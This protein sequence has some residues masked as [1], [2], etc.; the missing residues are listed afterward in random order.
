M[1]S[2]APRARRTTT[3]VGATAVAALALTLLPAPA[4]A[5]PAATWPLVVTE[6]A[7]DNTGYDDFE[8]VELT[9]T[10]DADLVL[11][12][13]GYQLAY[14][15]AD[16]GDRSRDK[17]LSVPA[18]TVVP[19][20]GTVVLW[21]Q[22]TAGNVDTTR[23]DA[24]DFRAFWAQRG[25]PSTD[26]P[27]VPLSGQAGIANGGDRGIRVLSPSGEVV[28]W[29]FVPA[30]GVGVDQVVQ[31]RTPVDA[32]TRAMDVLATL[33][34]PSPGVVAPEQLA[35]RTSADP[36][37]TPSPTDE[38][39]PTASPTPTTEPTA[40][41]TPTPT[42]T[43]TAAP[44]TAPAPPAD[45][46]RGLLQVTELM[47][48]ST[49]VG[50]SDGYEYVEVYNPTTRP[51]PFADHVI[52]YLYPNEDYTNASTTLWPATPADA[53]VPPGGTLVLWVKNGGNQ[54]LTRADFRTFWGVDL[55]D[56][57]IL[58]MPAGGMANGSPRGV[59]VMTQTG[60]TVSRA[61]YN[62]AG[63]R[64]VATDRGI[65]YAADAADFSRQR[66]I[67]TRAPSPGTVEAD[68]APATLTTPVADA[69]APTVAD[70]SPDVV[71]PAAALTFA[72]EVDDDRQVRRVELHVRSDLDAA[73]RVLSLQDDGSGRFATT[74]P[75]VDLIGKSS[76]TY[77]WVAS[78]GVHLVETAPV[79]LPVLGASDDPVRL[80]VADGDL[81]ARTA[82]VSVAAE[83][84]DPADL[85]LAV[86]GTPLTPTAPQLEKPAVF[87]V[88]VTATD[89]AFRNGIVL[90]SPTGDACHDG[91]VLTIFE[92]G[93]YSNVETV[94][95]S[96]PLEA[97]RPGEPVTVLVSAGTKAYP[98]DDPDEN[99]D[100]FTAI[101]PRLVLPDGRTLV[102]AGYTGG[103]IAMG[104]SA[105]KIGDYAATFTI[106]DDA[107]TAVGHA[108]DTTTVTD[109]THTVTG[110]DGTATASADVVVDNTAPVVAIAVDADETS[111][112]GLQGTIR[113]DATAT[114]A[115]SS[116]ASLTATLD[117]EPVTLPLTTSSLLLVPGEH[118]VAVTATDAAGNA[119]TERRTFTTPDE[120][121][122]VAL[123][124]PEDGAHVTGPA[125]ELAARV[126]DPTG[127]AL[128]VSFHK[129]F[130]FAATD[131]AVTA[132]AGTTRDA[133]ATSRD[134]AA[135]TAEQRAALTTT[136]GA[137]V[138][139][140][141]GDALPYQLFD[142]AVPAEAGDGARVV[143]TWDG[144]AESG[145]TV[146]LHV[147]D[148]AAGAW[149]EVDRHVGTG[150]GSTEETFTL[151]ADVP[152]AGHVAD[153]EARFLVQHSEGWAGA[154][155]STRA[156]P[157]TPAHPQDTP[158]PDYDFTLAWESD[159]QYYNESFYDH[160]LAIHE[161]LLDRRD[162]LNLQYLFH[163]GDIVDN[164]DQPYQWANADA[165]Y[166]MLDEAGLPYGVLA[167]NHD[168]GIFDSDY[169]AYSQYFGEARF[170]GNPWYGGSYRD[171]RGH[172]DL[173][174]AGGIDFVVVSMGWGPGDA[175]IAWMN[176]TLARFPNRVAIVN[177]HEYLL[178]TGGL[179]PV[180]QRIQ[181]EVV[182]T[183]PNV[184]MVMSG[185][186]HD[187]YTRIDRFDDD[188]DGTSERV[189]TQML[190]DYQGLP[191]GGQGFLRLLHFD[192][193]GEQI[194]VRTYSPSLDVYNSDDPSL[195]LGAQEFT[196]SYADAGITP[197]AKVLVADAFHAEVRTDAELTA[198]TS[199]TPAARP[200]A[201]AL[202]AT[203]SPLAGD[204]AILA[205]P[206]LP[207]AEGAVV[208]AAW[209]PSDGTHGW[210]VRVVDEHG[211]VV[212][213][214]VRT[215]TFTR[216]AGELPGAPGDPGT[217][218]G[219]TPGGGT[220]SGAGA[221]TDGGAPTGATTAL[222]T[223]VRG[224]SGALAVTGT[225]AGA[226]A[227]L[228]GLL[229]AAGAAAVV[230]R[231]RM[232]TS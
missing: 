72:A 115:T 193:E 90:P 164:W 142:V 191:E 55:P 222:G 232:T 224:G 155:L 4:G 132:A 68:Q 143:T 184:R 62:M 197:R 194:Q 221:G 94:T 22:Y 157:V 103:S 105:G 210:Y 134:A 140:A 38:P 23:H 101:N 98:C 70:R 116:V 177:L 74:V 158:R 199:V 171:N 107:F 174:T 9:N 146:V 17:P 47:V 34:A 163:T 183:N 15:F 150:D 230:T 124:T 123:L 120:T 149:A 84:G 147:W 21:V 59:E 125:V 19:A 28:G 45:S 225:D 56:E 138:R 46:L 89:A 35:D 128:T 104:D 153:G 190:F 57:R 229:L 112:A 185:H 196:I 83:S 223:G 20:G 145:A 76:Y 161:Y 188:G 173:L 51:V 139:T 220:G 137:G 67:G 31:F 44:G 97:V 102:P 211:A 172:Y 73:D 122:S 48:D 208:R 201:G 114:D 202:A 92:R 3:A 219:A 166:R 86:D 64:D 108:W 87:A 113:V 50:G 170:A 110:T 37:P 93:T 141:G 1:P 206:V 212:E 179:G 39:T 49:N 77:R 226:L 192:N 53:V 160:Q 119:H 69:A 79:T 25:G 130:R 151:A 205:V 175:E 136:D 207:G 186:Y 2:H 36:G 154:N 8:Y 156:T 165:A 209:T 61:Y 52:R 60:H 148:V 216:V 213:S 181:D 96:V 80:N 176:E 75:A 180:P 13:G 111:D 12:E 41:P 30:G 7:P 91:Q 29:S 24:A 121:P 152:V 58:E 214:D 27:V 16:S 178:T 11:G 6:I 187:A 126:G 10:T 218:G 133:A 88:E 167:G 117:G 78:D 85:A 228:G 42:A 182:A 227:L 40:T 203:A 14:T 231:R 106:P 217:G 118:H 95:A 198:A 131:A 5:A 43:P 33:A 71:D 109:G 144:A 168:V 169:T 99:N 18:G 195:D 100:D 127:D 189:V 32:G 82:P 204:A 159:T 66:L 54:A 81:L 65:H 135:L 200:A 63:A 129:A 215:V 26:Y 162:E